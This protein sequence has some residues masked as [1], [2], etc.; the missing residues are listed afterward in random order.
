MQY[1]ASQ[2]CVLGMLYGNYGPLGVNRVMP[3][4]VDTAV[5]RH[6]EPSQNHRKSTIQMVAENALVC[7]H[8]SASGL[9]SHCKAMGSPVPQAPETIGN[10]GRQ[11]EGLES[12]G[13]NRYQDS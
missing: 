9:G 6:R 4:S 2:S 8:R 3:L 1:I 11:A 5:P 13:I 12:M 10:I 7:D